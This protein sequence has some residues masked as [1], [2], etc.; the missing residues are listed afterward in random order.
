MKAGLRKWARCCLALWRFYRCTE[1]GRR[2]VADYLRAGL[3]MVAVMSLLR[4]AAMLVVNWGSGGKG[5][6][7]FK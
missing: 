1:K 5:S 7:N 2:D 6:V 3:F 4:L